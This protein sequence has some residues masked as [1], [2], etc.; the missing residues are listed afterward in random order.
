M[1]RK[2]EDWNLE[3]ILDNIN[4]ELAYLVKDFPKACHMVAASRR[5]RTATLRLEKL[6][7]KFRK[8]S[9][10]LGLK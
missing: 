3:D 2:E 1:Q 6:F 9:C 5:V 10:D 4:Y 7:R 8:T